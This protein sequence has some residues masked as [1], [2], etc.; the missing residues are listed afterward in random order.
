MLSNTKNDG[1][2]PLSTRGR[3]FVGTVVKDKMART[4]TVEW[5]RQRK[6]PKYERYEKRR[7]RIHAH[8]PEGAVAEV[9]DVVKVMETRPISKT[10][11][12]I[13]IENL[14][15]KDADGKKP[16]AKKTA[17]KKTATKPVKA[18]KEESKGQ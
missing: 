13:F 3:T 4:I 5:E 16:E 10:K 9:G 6:I 15:R 12:F 11:T 17:A 1:Q 2:R 14:S 18:E 8:L 7:T